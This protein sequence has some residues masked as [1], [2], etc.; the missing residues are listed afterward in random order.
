VI[1]RLL[2]IAAAALLFVLLSTGSAAAHSEPVSSTPADGSS[3][4]AGPARASVT[5]NEALQDYSPS[6]KV[7][8]P[9]GNLWSKGDATV[10][11]DTVSVELGE[12]GPTGDYTIAYR[13]TS[14]D[15]HTVTGTRTFTLTKQGNGTPGPPADAESSSDG[16][17]G[18]PPWAFIVGAA[19]LFAAGLAFALRNPNSKKR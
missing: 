7:V 6:L 17:D 2:G 14:A 19:V 11:G 9:D 5:F 13:V 8:G 18:V 1:R 3:L 12:L 4:D 10:K 15:G 16:G